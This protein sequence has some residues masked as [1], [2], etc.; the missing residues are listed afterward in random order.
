[1][2]PSPRQRR[3]VLAGTLLFLSL[4]PAARA[5]PPSASSLPA[6]STSAQQQLQDATH[7]VVVST[8]SW[9]APLGKLSVFTREGGGWK[10][11]HGPVEVNVGKKGLGWGRGVTLPPDGASAPVKKEGDAKAPAGVFRLGQAMGYDA[12]PPPGLKLGYRQVTKQVHC[13]DDAAHQDYNRIVELAAGEKGTWKSSEVMRRNDE[14]YRLI[15]LVDHNG[16]LE[17]SSPQKGSGS[18]IF[19]HVR[20]AA[21]S[22]TVG[23]TS[24]AREELT[25]VL[26]LLPAQGALLLQLPAKELAEAGKAWGLPTSAE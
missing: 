26:S 6:V 8:A 5:A 14:Q 11:L 19:L 10:R 20:R 12:A 9:S 3:A 1:M 22:P 7:V 23:C 21:G 17:D 18:C 25:R 4:S 24:M 13:V 2:N 16:L 15:A